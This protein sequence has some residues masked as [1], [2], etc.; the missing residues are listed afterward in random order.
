M[1]TRT[2]L[3]RIH[4]MLESIRGIE[5]NY[6]DSALNLAWAFCSEDAA[7][8]PGRASARTRNPSGLGDGGEMDSGF[9]TSSRPGMIG[10][11]TLRVGGGIIAT[12]LK[13]S[14]DRSLAQE[15]VVAGV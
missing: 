8:I 10:G 6:G 15:D 13:Q 7:V 14:L 3:L 2:P 9:A 1:P 12:F 5:K 4:D 11:E